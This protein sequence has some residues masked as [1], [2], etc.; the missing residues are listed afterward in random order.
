MEVENTFKI[1]DEHF[2]SVFTNKYATNIS[3]EKV[4]AVMNGVKTGKE[5]I[6]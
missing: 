4:V 5:E 2:V 1:V 3:K 6:L